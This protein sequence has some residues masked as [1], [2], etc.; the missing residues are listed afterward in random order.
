MRGILL[1]GLALACGM[2]AADAAPVFT[3]AENGVPVAM[4]DVVRTPQYTQVKL[5]AREALRQVCWYASGPN[6]PYLIAGGQR[7]AYLGGD[8]IGTCPMTRDYDASAV[9]VLRFQPLPSSASQVSLVEGQGGEN[10][11]I[12][13]KSDP[14]TRY[15]NILRV[16]LP[17]Q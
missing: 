16:A 7:Y 10:Q 13:P 3:M 2:A 5:E 6:S 17:P 12:D 15:W 4:I 8:N 11:M 1:C 14:T 9:M